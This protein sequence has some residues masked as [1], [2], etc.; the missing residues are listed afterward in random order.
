M[1]PSDR[2]DIFLKENHF[3]R[4][5]SNYEF[6]EQLSLQSSPSIVS[7]TTSKLDSISEKEYTDQLETTILPLALAGIER[8]RSVVD[9]LQK[10]PITKPLNLQFYKNIF[11][12]LF[13]RNAFFTSIPS[14]LDVEKYDRLHNGYINPIGVDNILK[15]FMVTSNRGPSMTVDMN[16][17]NPFFEREELL[18]HSTALDRMLKSPMEFLYG[19]KTA[20]PYRFFIDPNATDGSSFCEALNLENKV[21]NKYTDNRAA[22]MFIKYS[23]GMPVFLLSAKPNGFQLLDEDESSEIS[24]SSNIESSEVPERVIAIK[25]YVWL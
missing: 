21:M 15:T 9:L 22:Q 1:L 19:T 5:A 14:R 12:R 8:T 18:I 13:R 24:K 2:E 6:F 17:L 16:K 7:R 11:R 23:P 10:F 3:S 20:R 25:L 4:D